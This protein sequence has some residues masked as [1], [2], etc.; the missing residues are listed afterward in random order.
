MSSEFSRVEN[1]YRCCH[2]FG[3]TMFDIDLIKISVEHSFHLVK[4]RRFGFDSCVYGAVPQSRL[5]WSILWRLKSRCL[6]VSSC[7]TRFSRQNTIRAHQSSEWLS[8]DHHNPPLLGSA[9]NR[10]LLCHPM[11]WN[12][13][14]HY[15]EQYAEEENP[16]ARNSN[17]RA[18]EWRCY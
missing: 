16:R 4:I 18:R 5:L 2:Q 1:S 8:C 17:E 12:R 13:V 7:S 10:R 9:R 11:T 3:T 15:T 14:C 6:S